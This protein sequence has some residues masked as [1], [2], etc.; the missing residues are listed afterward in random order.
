MPLLH[1]SLD[2]ADSADGNS[3]RSANKFNLI[4]SHTVA[5]QTIT[6]REDLILTAGTPSAAIP[7]SAAGAGKTCLLVHIRSQGGSVLAERQVVSNVKGGSYFPIPCDYN[8]NTAKPRAN[9]QQYTGLNQSVQLCNEG[10]PHH[11]I[12]EV[13]SDNDNAGSL[14]P[15]FGSGANNISRIDLVFEY[16]DAMKVADA[17]R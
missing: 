9:P 17:G 15:T 10:M 4:L 8:W 7:L 11:L 6:L 13:F 16:D 2:Q 1:I 14:Y 5:S 12:V 3:Y